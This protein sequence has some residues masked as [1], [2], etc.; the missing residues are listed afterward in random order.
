[1]YATSYWSVIVSLFLSCTVS[2]IL[3]VL[4]SWPYP[5]STLILG[6]F[7]LHQIAHVGVSESRCL[8]LFS[9]EI[10]FEAFQL[11]WKSYLRVTDTDGQMAYCGITALCVASRGKNDVTWKWRIGCSLHNFTR[12]MTAQIKQLKTLTSFTELSNLHLSSVIDIKKTKY[13]LHL[14]VCATKT[15]LLHQI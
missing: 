10:I 14:A 13:E 11:V 7:R 6:V 15:T 4:C 8:K 5:Y 1:M 2:E 12:Q 3:H 9:R